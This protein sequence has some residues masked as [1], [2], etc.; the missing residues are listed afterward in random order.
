MAETQ[1][2]T[3][4]WDVPYGLDAASGL[5]GLEAMRKNL[6]EG[7]R[8]TPIAALM[9]MRLVSA[10]PGAAV[11]QGRPGEQHYNPIRIVH[12][13]FAATLFDATLWSAVQT[14]IEAGFLLTTLELKVNYARAMTMETGPVTCEGKVVHR[15][16]T[17]AIAEAKI[18]GGDGRLYAY[19]SS[20][21]MIVKP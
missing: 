12:G 20:T 6:A 13:G 1:S 9:G 18:L 3:V 7:A 21:L 4:T 2:H 10:K 17:V 19:G 8:R 14:T 11:M 15:G 16:R 5:S